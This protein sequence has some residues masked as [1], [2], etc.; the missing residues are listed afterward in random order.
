MF[1][2]KQILFPVDF[3][4]RCA[5]LTP[6]VTEF[7]RTYGARLTL[8]HVALPW[9]ADH[10]QDAASRL[11]SFAAQMHFE[12]IETDSVLITGDPAVQITQYAHE[13]KADLIIMPTHGYGPFRAF[14]LGSVTMKVLHDAWCPVLTDAHTE[15]IAHLKP[16]FETV[17]CAVDLTDKSHMT[18]RWAADFA[19]RQG[20]SLRIV[21]A[22]PMVI[23][24]GADFAYFDL[25]R[26]LTVAAQE[27]ID[28]LQRSEGTHG[29]VE[30]LTGEAAYAIGC[31]AKTAK[32]NFLVIGRSNL[33]RPMGRLRTHG[34]P[35]IR[36]SP[37]P[38][39]SI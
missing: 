13:K 19:T 14:L 5:A 24:M 30:I 6:M 11:S 32:A 28:Q 38:V 23:P 3:S 12:G 29:C 17:L 34:Y 21:H 37:C 31:A 25:Q 16:E 4:D 39:I 10:N 2:P 22:I 20:A 1:P 33:D 7:A 18:L 9:L 8:M 27:R 26:D 36:H 35:I 15:D